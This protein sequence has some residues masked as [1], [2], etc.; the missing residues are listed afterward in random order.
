MLVTR[1]EAPESRFLPALLA[2]GLRSAMIGLERRSQGRE[3]ARQALRGLAGFA[4]ALKVST[5]IS[6]SDSTSI[7][8]PD[9]RTTVTSNS[10]CR[11][12]WRPW[13]KPV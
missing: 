9:S 2:P 5:A 6:K 1:V 12:S 13:A 7:P 11:P 8:S 10:T 3:L 4:G